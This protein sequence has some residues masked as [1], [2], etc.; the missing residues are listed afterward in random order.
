MLTLSHFW[1]IPHSSSRAMLREAFGWLRWRGRAKAV[2]PLQQV[3]FSSRSKYKIAPAQETE[4]LIGLNLYP[5]ISVFNGHQWC[6]R[7]YR[8]GSTLITHLTWPIMSVDHSSVPCPWK[9]LLCVLLASS[10]LAGCSLLSLSLN[11]KCCHP[12]GFDPY[13]PFFLIFNPLTNPSI[14]IDVNTIYILSRPTFVLCPAQTFILILP[15]ISYMTY[16]LG[17]PVNTINSTCQKLSPRYS[18]KTCS[19]CFPLHLS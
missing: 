8:Q 1:K 2:F 15:D 12:P 14:V 17:F 11:S 13:C 19:I 3:C 9:F 10:Y 7:C 6:S 4:V 16:P 5:C 18:N